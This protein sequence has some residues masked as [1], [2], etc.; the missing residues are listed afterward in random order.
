M[1]FPD[2]NQNEFAEQVEHLRLEMIETKK[3]LESVIASQRS[4]ARELELAHQELLSGNEQLRIANEKLRAAQEEL[5]ATNHELET[6]SA[7]I[8]NRSPSE[9]I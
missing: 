8:P 1:S 6:F 4:M 9:E 2:I 7:T 5:E 3:R